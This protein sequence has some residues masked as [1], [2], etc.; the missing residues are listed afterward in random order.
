MVL[1]RE[2]MPSELDERPTI[3]EASDVQSRYLGN[4]SAVNPLEF[5][6]L[7][8]Y[9]TCKVSLDAYFRCVLFLMSKARL[10]VRDILLRTWEMFSGFRL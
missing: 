1:F 6:I 2:R 5:A 8:I 3:L 7:C 4:H 9:D 10:L